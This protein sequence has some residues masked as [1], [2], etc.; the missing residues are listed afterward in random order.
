MFSCHVLSCHHSTSRQGR[1]S[2]EYWRMKGSFG[3]CGKLTHT[4]WIDFD[5][6]SMRR[7]RNGDWNKDWRLK[8]EGRE[9]YKYYVSLLLGGIYLE[10]KVNIK[11]ISNAYNMS[12]TQKT[13]K[14]VISVCLQNLATSKYIIMIV[15][16]TE[17]VTLVR[18]ISKLDIQQI[19]LPLLHTKN[20]M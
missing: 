16:S 8:I 5:Q 9:L 18:N 11:S 20:E 19:Q 17:K 12:F 4:I 13:R 3:Q 7:L 6:C 2:E 15:V 14:D 1:H 10:N